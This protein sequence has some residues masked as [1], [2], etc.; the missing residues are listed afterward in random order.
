MIDLTK[1]PKE[2]PEAEI[3]DALEQTQFSH[4]NARLIRIDAHVRDV[5]VKA[6]RDGM[7]YRNRS[8]SHFYALRSA[9]SGADPLAPRED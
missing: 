1:I 8:P 7:A 4:Y 6:I 5:L 2:K 9:A 3:V